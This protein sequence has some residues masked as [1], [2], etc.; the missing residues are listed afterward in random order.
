MCVCKRIRTSLGTCACTQPLMYTHTFARTH[1]ILRVF[2]LGSYLCA[3]KVIGPTSH[4]TSVTSFDHARRKRAV[5]VRQLG[6]RA[7]FRLNKSHFPDERKQRLTYHYYAAYAY[8]YINA[9]AYTHISMCNTC[10]YAHAR[11]MHTT[12][13]WQDDDD[14]RVAD[15]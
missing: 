11:L 1:A 3:L 2:F 14:P 15:T 8:M 9:Y 10:T 13:G 7:R 5:T 12:H 6:Q 4:V